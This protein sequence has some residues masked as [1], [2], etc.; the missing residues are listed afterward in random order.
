MIFSLGLGPVLGF[1]TRQG[2]TRQDN[3]IKDNKKHHQENTPN[4]A[5]LQT[6]D[7]TRK[8]RSTYREQ[9]KA[10]PDKDK[11]RRSKQV[12]VW[13]G[14]VW[15]GV[16]WCG[17]VWCGVVWC[18]VVW[19]GVVLWRVVFWCSVV[20]CCDVVLCGVVWCGVGVVRCSVVVGIHTRFFHVFAV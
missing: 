11:E 8:H 12:V 17:V 9:D 5:T 4:E 13:C 14:V 6:Q 15:C 7:N 16:V 18:G 2:E 10:R 19:C 20:V 1:R 3:I